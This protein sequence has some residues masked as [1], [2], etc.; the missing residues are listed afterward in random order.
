[1]NTNEICKAIE[2][3][4]LLRFY[5]NLDN[6]DGFRVVEPHML[7]YNQKNHLALSAYLVR[8]ASES[9]G[10]GWREYLLSGISS[11]T[12]LSESFSG[13]RRGYKPKGGK[14]FHKVQCAL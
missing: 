5:Y 1:M 7:A 2:T 3:K 12:I 6:F 11:I 8:G 14:N 10:P 13:P 4:K 9:D